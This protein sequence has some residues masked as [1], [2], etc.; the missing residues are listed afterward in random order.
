MKTNLDFTHPQL[1][2][3]KKLILIEKYV[4]KGFEKHHI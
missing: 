4:A 2:E 3:K 1:I